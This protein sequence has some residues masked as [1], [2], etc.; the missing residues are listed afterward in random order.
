M[1]AG[2]TYWIAV[3]TPAGAGT[4]Q[5]RDAG[6]G[7]SPSQTSAQEDLTTLPEAWTPGTTYASAPVSAYAS[8]AASTSAAGTGGAMVRGTGNGRNEPALP[9]DRHAHWTLLLAGSAAIVAGALA[10]KVRSA[11]AR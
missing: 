9:V 1:T 3:L 6:S 7:G 4:V 11:H 10:L 2:T 5:F 8:R